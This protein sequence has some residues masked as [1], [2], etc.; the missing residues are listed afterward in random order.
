MRTKTNPLEGFVKVDGYYPETYIDLKGRSHE[1]AIREFKKKQL[2]KINPL[3]L[4]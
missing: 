2:E 1:K 3:R 4:I